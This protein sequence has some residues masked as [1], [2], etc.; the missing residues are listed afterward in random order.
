MSIS[1]SAVLDLCEEVWQWQLRESPELGTFCGLHH[2]DD[3]WDDISVE[4]FRRREV[5][6]WERILIRFISQKY[7]H[8]EN[9]EFLFK[10]QKYKRHL[11]LKKI[12]FSPASILQ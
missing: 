6:L 3:D 7:K 4:A 2:N 8:N 9:C 11:G 12:I 5:M 1:D 10:H